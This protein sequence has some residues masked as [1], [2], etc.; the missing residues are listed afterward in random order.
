L[1]K[2][3]A[4]CTIANQTLLDMR[5]DGEFELIAGLHYSSPSSLGC[6]RTVCTLDVIR[7]ATCGQIAITRNSLQLC[8]FVTV[9]KLQW[10]ESSGAK[11]H[12]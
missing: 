8:H 9:T 10:R 1:E 3:I 6:P 2:L 11:A 4:V 7:G 12:G 5:R